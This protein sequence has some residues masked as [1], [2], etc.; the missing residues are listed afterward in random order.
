MEKVNWYLTFHKIVSF[1]DSFTYYSFVMQNLMKALLQCLESILGSCPSY[2]GSDHKKIVFPED[3]SIC[4]SFSTIQ[5]GIVSPSD[6]DLVMSH[7]LGLRYAFMGPLETMHVNAEGRDLD[8]NF[9]QCRVFMRFINNQ[10]LSFLTTEQKQYHALHMRWPQGAVAS[11]GHSRSRQD[12][13][14]VL[15]PM[16]DSTQGRT[17]RRGGQCCG[18]FAAYH[19]A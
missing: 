8:G 1:Q 11:L 6:L 16:C 14:C 17:R 10:R 2:D 18:D 4:C 7:G 12:D 19:P 13:G 15:G 3:S 5:E 9:V